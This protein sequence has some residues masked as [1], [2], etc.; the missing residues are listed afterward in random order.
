[1]TRWT[2]HRHITSPTTLQL[3]HR[4]SGR[5]FRT[6]LLA[7]A[8]PRAAPFRVPRVPF[9]ASLGLELSDIGRGWAETELVA[10]AQ[11]L[12]H[13]GVLATMV[14]HTAGASA[15]TLAPP[16]TAVV[17]VEF[18]GQPAAASQGARLVRPRGD[19][20][21]GPHARGGRGE[22]S[23]PRDT[24]PKL[25]AIATVTLAPGR[26]VVPSM[27]A[28]VASGSGKTGGTTPCLGAAF[29]KRR[30]GSIRGCGIRRA[31]EYRRRGQCRFCAGL[32]ARRRGQAP[33]PT[34]VLRTGKPNLPRHQVRAGKPYLVLGH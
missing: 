27:Q 25:C 4:S 22:D 15:L 19:D 17:T 16:G 18:E 10:Q 33:R 3:L 24:E 34:R 14:D 12:V 13:A 26:D 5:Y 7:R 31:L 6:R 9:V 23:F 30:N 11:G 28:E 8:G 20:Q 1:M 29:R 2:R 32:G 21:A